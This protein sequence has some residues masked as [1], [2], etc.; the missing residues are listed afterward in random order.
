MSWYRDDY[1]EWKEIIFS[2]SHIFYPICQE[3]SD[4][5][6]AILDTRKFFRLKNQD[7]ENVIEKATTKPLFVSSHMKADDMF[8]KMKKKQQYFAVVVDEFGGTDGIVTVNDLLDE[9]VG[10]IENADSEIL[11]LE[12]GTYE[13]ECNV[14]VTKFEKTFNIDIDTDSITVGGWIIEH[15]GK[16]PKKDFVFNYENLTFTIVDRDEKRV[17]KAL[18]NQD[19]VNDKQDK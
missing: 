17:I 8:R 13:I 1:D 3:T 19:A 9:L 4:N 14:E 15:L 10:D 7:K 11:R 2:G 6:I 12:N 18:V 16:V 5:I